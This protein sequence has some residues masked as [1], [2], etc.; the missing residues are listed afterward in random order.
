MKENTFASV[1]LRFVFF[2]LPIFVGPSKIKRRVYLM[3]NE[4]W[5]VC[6]WALCSMPFTQNFS[7][8][9]IEKRRLRVPPWPQQHTQPTYH[10]QRHD[11][12]EYCKWKGIFRTTFLFLFLHVIWNQQAVLV[13]YDGKHTVPN[14]AV[15]R[16]NDRETDRRGITSTACEWN[17]DK[18]NTIN[19]KW[20]HIFQCAHG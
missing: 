12:C 13:P 4:Y 2:F 18:R 14:W 17:D 5:C 8:I 1:I 10:H 6:V 16:W 7:R 3:N 20:I 11:P 19:N 15:I 9:S